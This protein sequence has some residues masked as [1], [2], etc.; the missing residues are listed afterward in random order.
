MS[1]KETVSTAA[2]WK[3]RVVVSDAEF[4]RF[5]LQASQAAPFNVYVP[6][7]LL[8]SK[9]EMEG[10]ANLLLVGGVGETNHLADLLQKEWKLA[11]A[12]LELR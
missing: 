12:E 9:V 1:P 11:D 8:Q 10:K 6:L 4:G 5:N 3:I 2:H 7:R